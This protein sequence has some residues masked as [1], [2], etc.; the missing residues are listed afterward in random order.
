MAAL[1]V[2]EIR[3]VQQHGPYLLGGYCLG[4]T[5]AFEVARQLRARG[6]EIALLALFDTMNWHKIPLPSA[7]TKTYSAVERLVFH[8]ANIL[9]LDSAGKAKFFS[10]KVKTLRSRLPVWRGM[11][12]GKLKKNSPVARSSSRI[13]SQIWQANDRASMDYVPQPFAGTVTDFRPLR[14]YRMFSKPGLKWDQLAEGGEKVVVLPVFPAGMLVEPF[15]KH[16]GDAL[17]TAIDEALL[18]PQTVVSSAK[19]LSHAV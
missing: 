1:Y 9:R 16:L 17:R 14:Q 19:A 3:R 11:L 10:E 13:L 15:V 12:Q 8:A 18:S 4:G 7:W 5:I 6:E 2:R